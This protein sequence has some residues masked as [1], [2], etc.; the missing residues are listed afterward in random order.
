MD[1]VGPDH[2]GRSHW[3]QRRGRQPLRVAHHAG[4]RCEPGAAVG[5]IG[6]RGGENAVGGPRREQRAGHRVAALHGPDPVAGL[7]D[8]KDGAVGACTHGG[9]VGAGEGDGQLPRHRLGVHPNQQAGTVHPD[10]TAGEGDLAGRAGVSAAAARTVHPEFPGQRERGR[11]EPQQQLL[12]GG[13]VPA[14]GGAAAACGMA[15]PAAAGRQQ[16]SAHRPRAKL[17]LRRDHSGGGIGSCE[18]DGADGPVRLLPVPG[19]VQAR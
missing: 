1:G 5:H 11:V 14:R 9:A 19:Q 17:P 8:D 10:G 18:H 12:A 15:H 4:R 3:R 6:D 2:L 13:R 7:G 16:G